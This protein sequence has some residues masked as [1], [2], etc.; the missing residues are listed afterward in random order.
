MK[1]TVGSPWLQ[2]WYVLAE[3]ALQA[4]VV[5]LCASRQVSSA[6]DH[7]EIIQDQGDMGI[8]DG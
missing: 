1:L 7:R 3:R 8:R 2:V 4:A 5:V 6:Y